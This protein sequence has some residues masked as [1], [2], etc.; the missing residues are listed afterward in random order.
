MNVFLMVIFCVALKINEFFFVK[1]P[2]CQILS[3]DY[4]LA[5]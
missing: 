5:I 1:E 2:W 4:N 3:V